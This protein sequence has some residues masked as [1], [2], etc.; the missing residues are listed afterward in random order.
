VRAGFRRSLSLD[1][2]L[3][4]K[5]LDAVRVFGEARQEDVAERRM[6]QLCIAGIGIGLGLDFDVGLYLG[7]LLPVRLGGAD[8][9]DFRRGIVR[10]DVRLR[11]GCG[12]RLG[13]SALRR[14][15]RGGA[16]FGALGT[17]ALCLD[18]FPFGV[19]LWPGFSV[20]LGRRGLRCARLGSV[21]LGA[22]RLDVRLRSGSCI[23]LESG[24]FGLDCLGTVRLDRVSF[25]LGF[26]SLLGSGFFRSVK[27]AICQQLD[28]IIHEEPG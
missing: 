22:V 11:S 16:G 8:L 26:A 5:T 28:R 15:R 18:A 2:G 23:R 14:L 3:G 7:L 25:G 9:R 4:D 19:G 21:S 27:N 17:G 6:H 12:A 10:L 13:L 1:D 24:S 20:G